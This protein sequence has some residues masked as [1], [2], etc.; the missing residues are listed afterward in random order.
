MGLI[1]EARSH[2]LFFAGSV[3]FS[4]SL[5]CSHSALERN[6]EVFVLLWKLE[7]PRCRREMLGRTSRTHLRS[8]DDTQIIE[9]ST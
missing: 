8:N 7:G 1:L 3:R 2:P 4:V 9:S 6:M 5:G